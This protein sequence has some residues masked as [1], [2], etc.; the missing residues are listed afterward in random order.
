MAEKKDIKYINR[1][2][3][4]FKNSLVEFSKTYFPNTYTDF[5]PTSP[6]TMFMEMAAYVGDVLSFYL[7]N[8]IQENFIQYARQNENLY[9]LS[10]LLGYKPKVTEAASATFDIYQQVPSILDT[11]TNSYVPDYNFALF[12]SEKTQVSSKL[13]GGSNFLI[14]DTIDFSVS[15][16]SDP[17]TVSIYQIDDDGNPQYFLLKK[18]RQ[19]I[20]AQINSIDFTFGTSKQFNTL[21]I[22]NSNIIKILDITDSDGN[23]W[24]EV[25]Y[26]AQDVILD[27][28][29]TSKDPN[30]T[31]ESELVPN[32][33]R[34]K[35]VQ[36]RFV[37][38]FKDENTLELQ[39]G[40]GMTSDE[41]DAEFTPN[42]NNVGLGLPFGSDKLTTAFSPTSFT[43]TDTYGI[44]PSNTTLT[45]RYLTGGG[46]EANSPSNSLTNFAST[47]N[48]KFIQ[49]NL[50]ST[51]AQ[52]VFNNIAINNPFAASGGKDGDTIEEIRFNSLNTFQTQLRTVTKED[53]LVRALSL[54]SE[55][56]SLSKIYA[57]QEKVENILPGEI[58]SV[59]SLYVLSYNRNEKLALASPALKRNLTTYL[60]QYRMVNDSVK[61]R[62]GYIVNIGVNFE[63]ITLPNVNSNQV[64][65]TC[66]ETLK[67]YFNINNWQINQP[68]ILRE[69][70]ILLD[71]IEGV[72]TVKN[73]QIIN[74]V[75]E[76]L[77]Y[78]PFAYDIIGATQND[79]VYPSQDPSIFE[80]KYPDVD[81]KGKI[82]N[83]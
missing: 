68:I 50:D 67:N 2:F 7:D 4:S 78:S 72:Q 17:T 46:V 40:A 49:P 79:I 10:Y 56:G 51:L 9:T 41:N 1:E 39:F 44:S 24:Y 14:Q 8:Q 22:E 69:I 64:L 21:Q 43:F 54:P 65:T 60:S 32:L 18:K 30:L 81:I 42:P 47:S 33:L 80:V 6:G 66:I 70:Y 19:G 26:L 23:K 15:S 52:Y 38:R 45:V 37:S 12:F 13:A 57:E 27:S 36:R 75:G 35:K 62:D 73:V 31:S 63:L 55:Y 48:V 76:E 59:I 71:K 53:Y 29:K 25:P 83:F 16:S 20:S 82:V 11:T 3:D 5:S 74:N 61:V 28:I 34:L 77:G 58:P